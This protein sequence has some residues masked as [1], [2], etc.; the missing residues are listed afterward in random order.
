MICLPFLKWTHRFPRP[1]G[2]NYENRWEDRIR[3]Y[4]LGWHELKLDTSTVLDHFAKQ[5]NSAASARANGDFIREIRSPFWGFDTIYCCAST[6]AQWKSC[7]TLFEQAGIHRVVQR[8]ES[9]T[10]LPRLLNNAAVCGDAKV[11]IFDAQNL[12]D[13]SSAELL[14]W[15]SKLSLTKRDWQSLPKSQAE[16]PPTFYSAGLMVKGNAIAQYSAQLTDVHTTINKSQVSSAAQQPMNYL[17]AYWLEPGSSREQENALR[18]YFDLQ[19]YSKH[20]FGAEQIII[21]NIDY[22]GAIALELPPAFTREHALQ[23]KYLALQQLLSL[24]YELP[25]CMHDHDLFIKAPIATDGAA[26]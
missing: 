18:T 25:I 5:I 10:E 16:N 17:I 22:D 3:N 2:P 12:I 14:G 11:I 23:V 19:T 20:L 1:G 21:T 6:S 15:A 9:T 24:G 7:Q 4:L 13:F 8:L 26:N